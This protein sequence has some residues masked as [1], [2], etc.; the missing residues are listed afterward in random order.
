MA[1]YVPTANLTALYNNTTPGTTADPAALD[2]AIA[3][4]VST[5]NGNYD[6]QVGLVS[7]SVVSALGI[8]NV[9]DYG[10]SGSANTYTGTIASGSRTLTLTTSSHD[11]VAG[12][13]ISIP[14][15][16]VAGATLVTTVSSVS[17]ATIT[18][19]TAASTTATSVSVSHDDTA[20]I[21]AAKAY[22]V[23]ILPS[24]LYFP[25]GTYNFTSLGNL[26]YTG[27]TIEGSSDRE[28]VLKCTSSSNNHIAIYMDAFE[29]GSPS[30][31]FV[32]RC[33]VENITVEG[34][35]KT[36]S[37]FNVQGLARCNW[38]N[39][40]ARVGEPTDGR[41]FFF[42]G[43]QLCKFDNLFCSTEL[44]TMS[45]IPYYGLYLDQGV[46]NGLSVGHSTNN[47]FTSC[48]FEGMP[49]GMR[50]YLADQ[51]TF[52]GGSAESNTV[53]SC[54]VNDDSRYNTF[55][56]MAFESPSAS[57]ADFL[58]GGFSTQIIN[59]YTV[60]SVL[61]QGDQAKLS[62]GLHERIEV[63]SGGVKTCIENIIVNY[64]NTGSGGFIDSGT[65]TEWKNIYDQ[66]A[67]A[68]IYPLKPR[69]AIT[70][71][72]SPFTYT[73]NTGQY[74]EIV[75]QSGTISQIQGSRP[76]SGTYVR[77]TTVPGIHL[78]APLDSLIVT[79]SV[80]PSMSYLPHNG[81][82]G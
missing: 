13:G 82:Q 22:A 70:V 17:G 78:L 60:K 16:G 21:L 75:I 38:R 20:A 51:N 31:P 6:S 80:A 12:Q 7:E 19:A 30:A 66:D 55:I 15:A 69:V 28:V 49:I 47:V 26:A 40:V 65:A 72:A 53:Y 3:D 11:F 14:G 45:S 64:Y 77:P 57:S 29:S 67:A 44:D 71:T 41:A 18:V 36:A 54:I 62:G 32:E 59:C 1:G 5:I 23:S 52:I 34:N 58:D 43:V 27:L 63:Q 10:A 50:L 73:N 61:F 48:Y 42:K 24:K 79:Y 35:V 37:I 8:I 68:Y 2:N 39:V 56:G 76:G 74:V 33:N 46:R 81:F 4:I 25:K 9:K